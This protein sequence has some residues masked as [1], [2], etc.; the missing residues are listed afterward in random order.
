MP[1]E[2]GQPAD[3]CGRQTVLLAF[4]LVLLLAVA[5]VIRHALLVIY[6]SAVF[7]VVLKPG[8]DWLH[9]RSILGW[10]PGRGTALLL[11]VLVLC[12]VLGIL[13]AIAVPSIVSNLAQFA[14]TMTGRFGALENKLRG[15][16]LLRNVNL[17][18]VQSRATAAIGKVLPAVGGATADILTSLLLIAYFILDGAAMLKRVIRVFPPDRAARLEQTLNRAA[19]RMRHWLAGQ[20]ML[21]AILGTS[22]TVTFGIMHLPYFYLLGILAGIA[23]IVPLLGPLVTVVVASAVALTQSTWDVLGVVIFYAV[24]QQV[25]NGLLTPNIMKSQV[26]LS[27]AVVIAALVIGSELAGIAGALV[28]VPSAVLLAEIGNEYLIHEPELAG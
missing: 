6:V 24:Y 25:E 19:Q 22:A 11:I 26:Q 8:V 4:A 1:T 21:M 28:A 15:V 23:N 13:I 14:G 7:A 16:P 10:R 27:S 9:G 3:R 5:W 12:L 2:T 17:S 18:D 20:G